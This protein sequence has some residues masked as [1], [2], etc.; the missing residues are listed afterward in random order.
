MIMNGVQG[1]K[2][3]NL[4]MVVGSANDIFVYNMAKW[5]KKSMD[6]QIDIYE[7][8]PSN[9]QGCGYEYYDY[10]ESAPQCDNKYLSIFLDP[11][12]QGRSMDRYLKNK[13]YDAIQLHWLTPS[14]VMAKTYKQ[15]CQK[16]YATFWGREYD[17]MD[18][19]CLNSVYRKY[20]NALLPN[21][22]Y[23]VNSQTSI[24]KFASI[25]PSFK[26][27]YILGG[28]G[29]MPL[30]CLYELS[31]SETKDES[32]T[33]LSFPK[34]K[35]SVMLGYSG[36][37]LHQHIDVVKELA[38]RDDLKDKI[39]LFAPMTRGADKAYVEML[40]EELKTCGYSYTIFKGH[41]LTDEEVAR[42][43]NATDIALQLSTT[44]GFSRSIVECLCARA[45][46]VYGSW[47]DYSGY[48]SSEHF[49]AIKVE[50]IK[51]GIDK[52]EDIVRDV[53]RYDEMVQSNYENGKKH[54]LWSICIKDWVEAYKLAR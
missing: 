16:L 19:F 25:L 51:D 10:V 23:I 17:T 4:L 15:H 54:N 21:V 14:T 41:F 36:K 37:R 1:A 12:I 33:K 42:I 50:S 3:F 35:L 52:L 34:G 53:H 44:D 26:G 39:H 24:N 2:P 38:Q 11:I 9:L 31:L 32:K 13:Q 29:S 18:I 20:L 6:I 5:L 45:I 47:L 48:L 22:D 30:E 27:K 7:F 49:Q 43:R 8:Y 40:E 28:F 46:L